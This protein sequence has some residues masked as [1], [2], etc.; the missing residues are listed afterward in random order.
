MKSLKP[1]IL[2]MVFMFCFCN[3]YGNTAFG[4]DTTSTKAETEKKQA[5]KELAKA[6][7]FK[8]DLKKIE[9]TLSFK[10]FFHHDDSVKLARQY[11]HEQHKLERKKD[12]YPYVVLHETKGLEV[13]SFEPDSIFDLKYEV[14]GWYPYWEKDLYKTLNYSLITTVA[15]FSYEVNPRNGKPKSVHDWETTPLIDSLQARGKKV[16]LT[17]TNFGKSDNRRLL[18]D[19]KS[20]SRL[21]ENLVSL[22]QKRNGNGVCVDFEGVD[23]EDKQRYAR[24]LLLLSQELKKVNKDNLLYVS[25]PSVDWEKS[26]D[27]ETLIPVVDRFVVMGYNYYGP[28]SKV[29]GPVDPLNSGKTWEPFNISTSVDYYLANQVPSSKMVLALPFYGNLW[30]TESGNRSAKVVKSLGSRTYDY[31]RSSLDGMPVQYDSV[32]QSAWIVYTV[33]DGSSSFRQ[34][35]FDNDSTL[36][37]KLNYLKSKKLAGMGIWALGYDKGY[38]DLWQVIATELTNTSTSTVPGKAGQGVNTGSGSSGGSSSSGGDSGSGGGGDPGEHSGGGSQS[39]GG[40]GSETG[41]G[42]SGGQEASGGGE[43]KPDQLTEELNRIEALLQQITNYKTILLYVMVL[44]VFFGGI[45]FVIGMFSPDTRVYFFS[46]TAMTIYYTA[47]VLILL[48]VILRWTHI[49]DDHLV[50]AILAFIGGGVAVYVIN[51]ILQQIKSNQP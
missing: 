4:Q 7:K 16:L 51:K 1:I 26:I 19:Q 36:G 23:K 14:F 33:K 50:I 29:A 49:L 11:I 47:V 15:Y 12:N 31:I 17:V 27:F 10:N 45:G 42:T 35:W 13:K 46:N 6:G 39:S 30:D 18:R 2:S 48:I 20:V 8:A 43:E 41:G 22:V 44:A 21:V 32:S 37:I 28:T 9:K 25:V 40:S 24:F 34:C 3:P 38:N 5:T